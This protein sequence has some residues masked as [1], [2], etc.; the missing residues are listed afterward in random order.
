[1]VLLAESKQTQNVML[2]HLNVPCEKYGMM[3]NMNKTKCIMVS[4]QLLQT[5][6]KIGQ[7]E[8]E[9]VEFFNYL[10]C[11][12]EDMRYNWEVKIQIL[13][14]KEAFNHKRRLLCGVRV[15]L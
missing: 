2:E 3:I 9:R 12:M 8:I 1:M 7:E 13:I 11:M 14:A 10:G 5:N 15:E 4:E 6:I